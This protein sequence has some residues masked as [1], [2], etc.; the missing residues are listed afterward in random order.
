MSMPAT[1]A[2]MELRNDEPHARCH[3][4]AQTI[5]RYSEN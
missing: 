4:P 2:M 1:L 5:A 3:Q